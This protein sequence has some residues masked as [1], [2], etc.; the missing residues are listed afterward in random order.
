[1]KWQAIKNYEGLYEAS[2][3]GQI[4]SIDRKILGVDGIEYPYKG[5]ILA[6]TP[7]KN[8]RYYTVSLWKNNKG[9]THYVHRLVAEAFIPNPSSKPEINHIDGNRQNNLVTNLEWCTRFEN[10]KYAIDTGLKVYTNRLS[11]QEFIECLQDVIDG[12]SYASLCERVPYKVP[13]LSTKLRKL[14]RELGIEGDLD[15]SL[16]IQKINRARENGTKNRR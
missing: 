15:E 3:C 16:K 1:M 11:K 4:R 10:T 8:V 13:F 6:Q 9:T 14:A 12:E 2:E 7:N 5:R